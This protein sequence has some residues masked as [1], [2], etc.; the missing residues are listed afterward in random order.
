MNTEV[1]LGR[2]KVIGYSLQM[3]AAGLLV[4]S[5]SACSKSKKKNCS[6][7][8]GLTAAEIQVRESLKYVAQTNDASKKCSNCKLYKAPIK[9]G[10]CGTCTLL[11]GPVA[12]GG[13]CSGWQ[14]A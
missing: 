4:S 11:K 1:S 9:A 7:T 6:D 13:N 3:S 2:R 10:D 5:L 14:A 12:P 8:S